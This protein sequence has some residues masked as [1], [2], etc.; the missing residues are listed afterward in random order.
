MF[1]AIPASI[2]SFARSCVYEI[3]I[4]YV[5]FN[6]LDT[7]TLCTL[8]F[9]SPRCWACKLQND[10]PALEIKLHVSVTA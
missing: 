2:G 1:T 9:L 7:G 10:L 8:F 5:Q 4:S 6:P 3:A